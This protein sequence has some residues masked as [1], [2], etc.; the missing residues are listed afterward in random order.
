MAKY[1]NN[2]RR[3]VVVPSESI[4]AYEQA[5]YGSWLERYYN[6]TGMFEEVYAVSPNEIGVRHAHGMTIV[7]VEPSD[8]VKWLRRLH[9]DVV[10][11]YGG[12][13]A[14]DLVCSRRLPDVP[15]VVS[16]HDTNPAL[17]HASVRY[18]DM[19][20]CMSNAVAEGVQARGADPDRIRLLPN[21]IDPAVFHPIANPTFSASLEQ[22]FPVRK[23][24]LH[25]GRKSV[26]KNIETVVRALAQL[27]EDYGCIFV[28]RGD[29]QTYVK[30]GQSLDVERRCF[31][32]E[33][34]PNS[35]LPLWYSACD[36]MCTPS[37]W[38]GFG[39][40]FIEAAACGAAIVTSNIAP[41]NE[42]LTD[43]ESAC[44][45]SDYKNPIAL[46]SAVRSVC[47]NETFREK[48]KTGALEISR[49]FSNVIIDAQEAALYREAMALPS[50]S[51]F[52]RISV[53]GLRLS[54][55]LQSATRSATSRVNSAI[56]PSR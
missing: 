37:L 52:Q 9:P 30:L 20:I 27:P 21:R 46:A 49:A 31:W 33:S 22:R 12:Y 54:L 4:A 55:S 47:E 40:V 44:L 53:G 24:L 32:I 2:T 15:V 42:Y 25:V 26:Q 39:I 8:F 38:E 35:E 7:G 5:G 6:P 1:I 13:W 16:V 19:L 18:A 10:R 28:G 17:I 51:R 41:M 45:V 34:V 23:R 3:L 56:R 48:I 50:L 43:G 11:G 29:P 36:C 14:A